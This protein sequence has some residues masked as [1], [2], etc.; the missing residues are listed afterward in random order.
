[1]VSNDGTI[2]TWKYLTMILRIVGDYAIPARALAQQ[3]VALTKYLWLATNKD[4][5]D[6]LRYLDDSVTRCQMEMSTLMS[7][8][9]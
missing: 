1:M 4:L 3:I 2:V 8:Q 5:P 7:P 9:I 6:Q